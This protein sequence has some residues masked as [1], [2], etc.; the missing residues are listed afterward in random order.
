[1]KKLIKTSQFFE[2]ET[3]LKLDL[4]KFNVTDLLRARMEG[5]KFEIIKVFQN[6]KALEK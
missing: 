2:A 1:M 5:N 3:G 6:L 4:I